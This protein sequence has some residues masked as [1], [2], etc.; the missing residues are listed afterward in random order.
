[1]SADGWAGNLARFVTRSVEKLLRSSIEY[2]L[3]DITAISDDNGTITFSYRSQRILAFEDVMI[4]VSR[5]RKQALASFSPADAQAFVARAR[6][7]MGQ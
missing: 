4:G 3:A 1:M 7:V 2:P 5:S 6:E